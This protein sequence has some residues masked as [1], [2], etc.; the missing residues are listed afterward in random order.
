MDLTEHEEEVLEAVHE[1][2]TIGD[3]EWYD[4][5]RSQGNIIH[6]YIGPA[7]DRPADWYRLS[8]EGFNP[9]ENIVR[10][11]MT[12]QKLWNIIREEQRGIGGI[13]LA[14]GIHS[15]DQQPTFTTVEINTL[16]KLRNFTK[17]LDFDDVDGNTVGMVGSD[18]AVD[19]TPQSFGVP[20]FDRIVIMF[21]VIDNPAGASSKFKTNEFKYCKHQMSGLLCYGKPSV[22]E[23]KCV[24]NSFKLASKNKK[25]KYSDFTDEFGKEAYNFASDDNRSLADLFNI[26]YLVYSPVYTDGS[27][28][29]K[30]IVEQKIIDDDGYHY[31][32]YTEGTCSPHTPG[33]DR[34]MVASG[35]PRAPHLSR[36][37]SLGHLS[38]VGVIEK[39]SDE[40]WEF[41]CECC[42]ETQYEMKDAKRPTKTFEKLFYFFDLETVYDPIQCKAIPISNSYYRLELDD[43]IWNNDEAEL[44][45]KFEI[46]PGCIY[47]MLKEIHIASQDHTVY[48]YGFNSSRFDNYLV[49]EEM[50]KKDMCP[51]IAF[52]KDK[53]FFSW[54]HN[55]IFKDLLTM[56]S[57]IS[58]DGACK[59][60]NLKHKKLTGSVNF[61]ELNLAWFTGGMDKIMEYKDKLQKYNDLDVASLVELFVK[62]R[63][64]TKT[65][66]GYEIEK[67]DTIG[68][69]AI[70]RLMDLH[71]DPK[72]QR[73][74]KNIKL[75]AFPYKA[76][77]SYGVYKELKKAMFASFSYCDRGSYEGD[78]V[79]V[80]VVSLYPY[81]MSL[82]TNQYG[83]GELI[84]IATWHK[85]DGDY[86]LRP[87]IYEV[88]LSN[89]DETYGMKF[90]PII[91]D[92]VYNFNHSKEFTRYLYSQDI[93]FI[94]D[95][96]LAD[97]EIL[98]GYTW[99][100]SKSGKDIFSKY[101]R[102]LMDEKNE[103][104]EM[105]GTEN[106][107]QGIREMCK[108]YMN[109]LSGKIL[110]RL[111]YE[112]VYKATKGIDGRYPF[113]EVANCGNLFISKQP[114]K[115]ISD[116]KKINAIDLFGAQ[117]YCFARIHMYKLIKQIFELGDKPIIIETDSIV[118]KR[119]TLDNLSEFIE[120]VDGVIIKLF[121]VRGQSQG[122]RDCKS[123][124]C[125][126][127]GQLEIECKDI[128]GIRAYRK[129]CYKY[130][131]AEITKYRFKGIHGSARILDGY[132]EKFEDLNI[133]KAHYE[134]V[135]GSTT[136][137]EIRGLYLAVLDEI[138]QP[139]IDTYQ[140]LP[141]FSDMASEIFDRLMIGQNTK[142]VV[143]I[144]K[145]RITSN[146]GLSCTIDNVFVIKDTIGGSSTHKNP[147]RTNFM[148]IVNKYI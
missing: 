141:K 45:I 93:N 42:E 140:Q 148:K 137:D 66:I 13:N 82:V 62:I 72:Y 90:I 37:V 129:K 70:H 127:F 117:L 84:K 57:P 123:L 144:P 67:Y 28:K 92:E 87:G 39:P 52:L 112:S 17:T 91:S 107:N 130:E 14:V 63:T 18:I 3:R 8:I 24:F 113:F 29:L 118:C 38:Y 95:N 89:W 34:K 146:H 23:T 43:E 25:I 6:E 76:S 104:D 75:G 19:E 74:S 108:A 58:L 68:Q 122:R 125:K 20:D 124:P 71:I 9:T 135:L 119:E 100:H 136:E 2:S 115:D 147:T 44:K 81:V 105:K 86:R 94:L 138:Y 120:N 97:I 133:L 12:L 21:E 132:E 48:V 145:K 7:R 103:Q 55:I 126:E 22:Y 78:Y 102:P 98:G 10:Y 64:S 65:L 80:D 47:K 85:P 143:C 131:T 61:H 88:T 46:G 54:G 56:I 49:I 59:Q 73:C 51:K 32:L 40:L 77:T 101:M 60:F 109:I 26:N 116:D 114:T 134:K 79:C 69:I 35:S 96:K 15:F 142:T 27:Y 106:Y 139:I 111:V 5:E 121:P 128:T 11:V 36:R 4:R 99:E 53:I 83:Y 31:F 30:K 41:K 16:T 1:L 33:D 50:L 110:Q